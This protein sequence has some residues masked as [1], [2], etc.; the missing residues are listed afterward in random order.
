MKAKNTRQIL[1]MAL[2]NVTAHVTPCT[3]FQK[4]L[5]A[6][7][8][9][10]PTVEKSVSN[11]RRVWSQFCQ[12]I[13]SEGGEKMDTQ[14]APRCLDFRTNYKGKWTIENRDLLFLRDLAMWTGRYEVETNSGGFADILINQA[15]QALKLKRMHQAYVRYHASGLTR[16][17]CLLLAK[18]RWFINTWR[19]HG[20]LLYMD[21]K[22]PWGDSFIELSVYT[23]CGWD[24]PWG[25]KSPTNKH[26]ERAW[27]LIDELAFALPDAAG[28]AFNHTHPRK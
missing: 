6:E 1:D 11:H 5:V 3:A 25:E 23:I 18:A 14:T 24:I 22:H 4:A 12:K 17:H 19:G 16:E 28:C 8:G 10:V 13:C 2:K 15:G 7:I 27:N 20:D 26:E 21:G 9:K